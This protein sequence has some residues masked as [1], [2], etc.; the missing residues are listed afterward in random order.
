MK[1]TVKYHEYHGLPF[2]IQVNFNVINKINFINGCDFDLALNHDHIIGVW[3]VKAW[4]HPRNYK[5]YILDTS[6]CF[7]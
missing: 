4:K 1:Y 6:F 2:V 5:A 3:K 7:N